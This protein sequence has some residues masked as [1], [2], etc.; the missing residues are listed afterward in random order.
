MTLK[1][2]EFLKRN[3][4]FEMEGVRGFGPPRPA[5]ALTHRTAL[6]LSSP[7]LDVDSVFAANF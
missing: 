6:Q 1:P 5:G 4:Y 3:F 7:R 2:T